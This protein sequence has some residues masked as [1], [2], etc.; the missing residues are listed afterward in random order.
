M[1]FSNAVSSLVDLIRTD[2]RLIRDLVWVAYYRCA[3]TI[4]N[5]FLKELEESAGTLGFRKSLHELI[6]ESLKLGKL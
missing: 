4:I 5:G 3:L 1:G 2:Y 6:S